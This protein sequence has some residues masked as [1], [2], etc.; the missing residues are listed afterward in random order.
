MP[1]V[2][3]DRSMLLFN[4]TLAII[5]R[6]REHVYLFVSTGGIVKSSNVTPVDSVLS[7]VHLT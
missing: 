6:P 7:G 2:I 4:S 5:I 3:V 1:A